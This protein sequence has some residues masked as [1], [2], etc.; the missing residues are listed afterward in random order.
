MMMGRAKDRIVPS[1]RIRAGLLAMAAKPQVTRTCIV[2]EGIS[3][4]CRAGFNLE[5]C[6]QLAAFA[7]QPVG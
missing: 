1:K 7:I 3:G 5:R 6:S 4:G 2:W